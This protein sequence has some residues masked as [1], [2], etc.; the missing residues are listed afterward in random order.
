MISKFQENIRIAWVSLRGQKLRTILTMCIIAFGIMS[1][2][3]MLTAIDVLNQS[4]SS[5]FSALGANSYTIS[6][7]GANLQVM[8]GNRGRSK[9]HSVISYEDATRFK[10][11]FQD[12]NNIV[13]LSSS[14]TRNAVVKF[15]NIKTN[16]N[17]PI[18]GADEYYSDISGFEFEFGRNF[19]PEELKEG[20]DVA[21]IGSELRKNLFQY[22][23]GIG[24][25]IR[26]GSKRYKVVGTLKSKGASFGAGNDKNV[27]IP[28]LNVRLNYRTNRTSYLIT[29]KTSKNSDI[30]KSRE[31]ARG[32]FRAVRQDKPL[33]EDS[34]EL[35]SS[36]SLT[37]E[38]TQ[39]TG[40]LS[41]GSFLI[42]LITLLGALVGLLNIM[43]VSVTERTKEI[44][45]R[46]AIGATRKSIATQFLIEAI[47]ICQLGG[48]L[49]VLLGMMV[50]N[51]VTVL[52]GGA[53]IIPWFWIFVAFFICL[54]VGIGSGIYPAIKAAKLDPVE[55]LRYE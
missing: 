44:G 52:V 24:E 21:I 15:G 10:K 6:N 36:E 45:I 50:G 40:Y 18:I 7:R 34:F 23:D 42:A 31:E 16:P 55:S 54:V 41:I 20:K 49:G 8:G 26:I 2:V 25:D 32:V 22:S 48:V 11:D 35:E 12:Q 43:L 17:I 46:K 30:S 5:N 37:G 33:D 28:L 29:I 13:S 47:L 51:S 4:I 19:S 27:I 53:F 39:M 1:L 14:V 9:R 3:G 38:L